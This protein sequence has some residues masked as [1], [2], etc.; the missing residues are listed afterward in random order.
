MNEDTRENAMRLIEAEPNLMMKCA[1]WKRWRHNRTIESMQNINIEITPEMRERSEL[2]R[3][4]IANQPKMSHEY[5]V[6]QSRLMLDRAT[7]SEIER[8]RRI[9]AEDLERWDNRNA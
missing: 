9:E 5:Y 4:A 1:M 3:I 2:C 8:L 7:P 6:L